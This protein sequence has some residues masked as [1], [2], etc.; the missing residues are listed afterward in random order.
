MSKLGQFFTPYWVA[1]HLVRQ[2]FAFRADDVVIEPTCGKGSFLAAV[3]EHIQ[4]IGVEL[5]PVLAAEAHENTG[6]PV[7]CGNILTVPLDVQPTIAIG[8]PPFSTELFQGILDRLARVMQPDSR[9][10][11]ILPAY[12]F[13]YSDR[14]H[15]FAQRWVIRTE[16]IPRTIFPGL[17]KPLVFGLFELTKHGRLVGFSLYDEVQAMKLMS[18]PYRELM[19]SA[20]RSVWKQVFIKAM[21]RLGGVATLDELYLEI[22]PRRPTENVWWKEKIRQVAQELCDRTKPGVYQLRVAA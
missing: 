21:A 5:D 9:A 11:F 2:H 17:S 20:K 7:I 15:R 14:A 3:P 13:Q 16:H 19:A 8:N 12:F 1:E 10:G 22:A 18:K 4:A 6:R